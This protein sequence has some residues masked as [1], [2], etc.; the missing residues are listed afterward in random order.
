[1]FRS[2][3]VQGEAHDMIMIRLS[4]KGL[5]KFK[6]QPSMSCIA[7]ILHEWNQNKF[8]ELSMTASQLYHR[9]EKHTGLKI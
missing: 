2:Q 6:A 1:M 7:F 3:L 4:K 8:L 9:N 5:A